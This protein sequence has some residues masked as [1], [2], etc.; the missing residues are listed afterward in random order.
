MS[1]SAS[2]TTITATLLEV[3]NGK[4]GVAAALATVVR[5]SGSAPQALGAKLLMLGDGR[6]L[7]TVGGGAI[8][9]K[10]QQACRDTLRSGRSRMVEHNLVRD[11]GMCCGGSMSVFVEYLQ[12]ELRLFIFGAGHVAQA[13]APMARQLGFGV[14]VLDDRENFLEEAAF[15]HC[16]TRAFDA[17]E[18]TSG[19]PD[20]ND[21][22][23]IVIVTHDHARDEKALAQ[24]IELP[25][26]YLGMIGSRR[27]VHRVLG[28][29]LRRY[30]ERAKAR[31][32]LSRVFAPI[33]LD[34]GGKTPPEIAV[35]IC[36][37]LIA[38]R[39][40]GA[41]QSCSIV[42]RVAEGHDDPT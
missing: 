17:D 16:D 40:T 31:P 14:T 39:H 15:D 36:A 7:G 33:G 10:V 5:R 19:I 1:G 35:S 4:A 11:L 28:R 27:K 29:I 38:Q 13:L 42:D 3:L 32:D 22:D 23:Y 25:H 18:V 12:P 30:D 2:P 41:G 24:L 20:L 8:E 21:R 6:E 26:A 37:Q 34:L 9:A